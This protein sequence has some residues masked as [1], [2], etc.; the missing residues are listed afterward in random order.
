MIDKDQ[1]TSLQGHVHEAE[2]EVALAGFSV[3]ESLLI[4]LRETGV[5]E[6]SEIHGL[7]TDAAEAHRQQAR[8]DRDGSSHARV[9]ELI[10]IL[11]NGGNSPK[12]AAWLR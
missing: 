10:E 2:R 11:R 8:T 7:L 6:S 1:K 5:L 3:L 4:S 9:A 12:P